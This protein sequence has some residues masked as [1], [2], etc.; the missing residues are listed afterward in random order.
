MLKRLLFASIFLFAVGPSTAAIVTHDFTAKTTETGGLTRNEVQLNE[1]ISGTFQYSTNPS[2]SEGFSGSGIFAFNLYFGSITITANSND[3]IRPSTGGPGTQSGFAFNV[4]F[5]LDENSVSH[6]SAVVAFSGP[7][8]TFQAYPSSIDLE[9]LYFKYVELSYNGYYIMAD[10]ETLS[11]SVVPENKTW[12]LFVLGA[13]FLYGLR[14]TRALQLTSSRDALLFYDR[15]FFH[16]R[17]HRA[18]APVRGS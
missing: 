5:D 16:S 1:L 3:L 14:L 18:C 6:G 8:G 9:P 7:I 17:H 13:V 2:D 12:G 4:L 15:Q 11:T 10:L